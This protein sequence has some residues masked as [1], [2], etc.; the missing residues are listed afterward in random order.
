MLMSM[1][2]KVSYNIYCMCLTY[3][4]RMMSCEVADQHHCDCL[5]L[6]HTI[7]MKLMMHVTFGH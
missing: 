5:K 6:M 2:P 7:M 1:N 4:V 3:S